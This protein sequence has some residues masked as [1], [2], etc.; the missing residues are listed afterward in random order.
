M[1]MILGSLTR[2]FT[3]S[4]PIGNKIDG[5]KEL[6]ARRQIKYVKCQYTNL[7]YDFVVSWRLYQTES[8]YVYLRQIIRYTM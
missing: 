3:Y 2:E 4:I 6:T 1:L 8:Q 5:F 7:V